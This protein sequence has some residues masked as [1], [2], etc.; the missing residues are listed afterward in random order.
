MVTIRL[1]GIRINFTGVTGNLIP[2]GFFPESFIAYVTQGI[3]AGLAFFFQGFAA[4]VQV[5][6]DDVLP[7][8][9]Y[10]QKMIA[11]F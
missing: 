7:L 8:V 4:P 5:G 9:S 3:E 6:H 10:H 1:T 11:G 2:P